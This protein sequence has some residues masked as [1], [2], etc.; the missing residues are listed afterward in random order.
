MIKT[1]ELPAFFPIFKLSFPTSASPYWFLVL[2]W[3][4]DIL[5]LFCLLV[6]WSF[7]GILAIL[8]SWFFFGIL[9][10]WHLGF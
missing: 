4:L 1:P 5:V 3:C 6:S 8:A 7:F 10:S 9:A 2:L